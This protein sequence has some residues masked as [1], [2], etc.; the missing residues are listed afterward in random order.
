M[1]RPKIILKPVDINLTTA[2]VGTNKRMINI[3]GNYIGRGNQ[4]GGGWNQA[5]ILASAFAS[6]VEADGGVTEA[7][8]CLETTITD[9]H[10]RG[11]WQ[12]ASAV[13]TAHGYKEGKLYAVKGGEEGADFTFSRAGIRYRKGPTYV[14]EV[15]Y[16][17]L[18]QSKSFDNAA[19]TKVNL[20]ATANDTTAP[21]GTST[22]DKLLETTNNAAHAVIQGVSKLAVPIQYTATVQVKPIGR[23]WVIF[24][25]SDGANSVGRYFNVT[26]GVSGSLHTIGS[27][28]TLHDYSIVS[29]DN[30]FFKLKLVVTT[31]SSSS[32]DVIVNSVTSDGGATSFVGDTTK[33]FYVWQAQLVYGA[34][35]R[36][37]F[38]T[39]DRQNVPTPD[40]TNG[41]CPVLSREPSRTNLLKN[42]EDFTQAEWST[43]PSGSV[44]ITPN[45]TQ[46]PSGLNKGNL[47][48]ESAGTSEHRIFYSVNVSTNTNY[49]FSIYL[50]AGTRRY[51]YFRLGTSSNG[52]GL[53]VDT[54]NWV[55]ANTGTVG[56]GS[57][58]SSALVPCLDAD[59][60]PTDWYRVIITYSV[61]TAT[62][63]SASIA[64]SN[65]DTWGSSAS[66]SGSETWYLWGAQ[67]EQGSY[68]TSYIP[69]TITTVSRI[70]DS[71]TAVTGASALIGQ[72]EGTIYFEGYVPADGTSKN[73]SLSDGTDQNRIILQFLNTNVIR[74]FIG[75]G[76]VS[77]A[78]IANAG[79]TSDTLYR[80]AVIYK[81]N[82]C[83]LIV[84]GVKEGE[85]TSVTVPACSRIGL[86][87]GTGSNPFFGNIN[88]L[89][90]LPVALEDSEAISLTTIS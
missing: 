37:D 84:N 35:E 52:A 3:I 80:V 44:V 72:T 48:T 15:P 60:N 68:A 12:K 26:T 87:I 24:R 51:V 5:P 88:T 14:E 25:L 50:K 59:G 73:I 8:S 54:Q 70:A 38:A 28:F 18:A 31:A 11:L 30:G 67:L 58:V 6:R 21:D 32:I 20:T 78:Q 2:D 55:I 65:T 1:S 16:N 76:G 83:A 90:I 64:G 7:L 10:T 29:S 45:N 89:A 9:L 47:C 81:S 39:T 57:L 34:S 74:A 71:V 53:T 69:T 19:W 49:T 85:D 41:S 79:F 56:N 66:S 82:Y 63:H 43:S 46:A 62:N 22:A 42:S 86:D 27:E 33:G 4:G 17:L 61:G 13:W 75:A 40:F 23:D 36:E 77:Q